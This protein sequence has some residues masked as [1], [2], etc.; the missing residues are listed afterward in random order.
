MDIV[1]YNTAVHV[2]KPIVK[3]GVVDYAVGADWTPAAGDVKFSIDGGAAVNVTNLPVAIVMG[4]TAMW[5]FSLVAGETLGKQIKIT[6]ADLATKAVEDQFIDLWTYGNAS[7]YL[8]GGIVPA[9][10]VSIVGS[11]P[12]AVAQGKGALDI[13]SGSCTS[14]GT[15]TAVIDTSLTGFGTLLGRGLIWRTG[16]NAGTEAKIVAHVA[17]TGTL[18]ISDINGNPMANATTSGDTYGIYG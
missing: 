12:A 14:N 4:N 8:P 17:G 13:I 18:T 9:D 15:T 10:M 3:R 5:D 11:A 2:Y 16:A 6:V 7:A 1:L